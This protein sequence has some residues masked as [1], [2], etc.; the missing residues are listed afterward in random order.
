M[1]WL[2][3]SLKTTTAAVDLISEILSELGVSGIEIEDH[4]P[5]SEEEKAQMYV[6]IL[7][8]TGEDDGT[9]VISF[10][11]EE[12][13]EGDADFNPALYNSGTAI[14]APE[15][16]D[17][18]AV[19]SSLMEQA[20]DLKTFGIDPG[21]LMVS[22]SETEDEDWAESW[23]AYFH[24]FTIGE[25]VRIAPTW[26]E[27][28]EADADLVTLRIDPGIAF[29]T[30]THETT[31]LCVEALIRYIMGDEDLLDVGCGSGILSMAAL[32]LGA[33]HALAIDIDPVATEVAKENFVVNGFPEK[34]Y[35]VLTGDLITDETLFRKTAEKTYPVIV[36]NILAPVLVELTPVIKPLLM[37]GGI[38]ITS[39]IVEERAEEVKQAIEDAGMTLLEENH[40]NDWV[41]LIAE[42]P[43]E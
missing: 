38:Y 29:G 32:G 41:C 33:G 8:E 13:E 14:L 3:Y 35:E 42:N 2:K 19:L 39:G 34:S 28:D 4:V 37:P 7:P 30:G 18:H 31:K 5:L 20:A 9:A 21:P 40:E 12:A 1:K 6:D 43:A 16:V 15:A 10:Y 11:L 25:K 17:A 24:A 23:K 36:A 27:E 22:V 26:E